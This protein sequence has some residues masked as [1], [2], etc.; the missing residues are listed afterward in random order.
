MKLRTLLAIFVTLII[1]ATLLRYVQDWKALAIATLANYIVFVGVFSASTAFGRELTPNISGR[2]PLRGLYI[3]YSILSLAAISATVLYG[4]EYVWAVYGVAVLLGV[5]AILRSGTQLQLRSLG[6]LLGLP[7]MYLAAGF[8]FTYPV[9]Y[10]APL[11]MLGIGVYGVLHKRGWAALSVLALGAYLG[12]L[13]YALQSPYATASLLAAPMGGSMTLEQLVAQLASLLVLYT[14]TGIAEEM[15]SRALI[16]VLG[17][18]LTT[19]VFVILH[20]PSR[21]YGLLIPA[22]RTAGTDPA[23]L[24]WV[25]TIY[26]SNMLY[27][28]APAL[29][30]AYTYLRYGLVAAMIL[31]GLFDTLVSISDR[32]FVLATLLVA[33]IASAL[34]RK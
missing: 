12:L 33:T 9:I 25:A 7:A 4:V 26:I 27:L 3:L 30:L 14:I 23:T 34:S 21:F 17:A 19:A 6:W 31:H 1:S 18:G 10:I 5:L 2:G 13:L 8:W 22:I 20:V 16:P 32:G 28:M 11:V 29:I 15:G 24:A